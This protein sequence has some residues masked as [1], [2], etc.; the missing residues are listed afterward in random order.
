MRRPADRPPVNPDDPLEG[1]RDPE[2]AE[3]W[4]PADPR[5]RKGLQYAEDWIEDTHDD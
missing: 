1:Y 3:R 4:V 5:D 2:K